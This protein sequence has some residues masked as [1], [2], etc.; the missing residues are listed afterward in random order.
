MLN[1][2]RVND[3]FSSF[4][5]SLQ[6]CSHNAV[7]CS[8]ETADWEKELQAELQEYEVVTEADN[9]DDNWD[10]EIEKMLQSDEQSDDRP[11][12]LQSSISDMRESTMKDQKP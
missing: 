3:M 4:L 9:R 12:L 2:K 1:Q 7:I 6:H 10:K 11:I 5:F 8:E